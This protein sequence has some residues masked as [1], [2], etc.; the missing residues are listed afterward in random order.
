MKYEMELDPEDVS[1]L[2]VAVVAMKSLPGVDCGRADRVWAALATSTP[3][4]GVVRGGSAMK[5]V[6]VR[7]SLAAA[8]MLRDTLA[9]VGRVGDA[10]AT[11]AFRALDDGIDAAHG[12][13]LTVETAD[14][15]WP[16][17]RVFVRDAPAE[18]LGPVRFVA[19]DVLY[20]CG[21]AY[22]AAERFTFPGHRD[23]GLDGGAPPARND[24]PPIES[25]MEPV[26][27]AQVVI[28][29]GRLVGFQRALG[30]RVDDDAVRGL[31]SA[32]REWLEIVDRGVK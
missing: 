20:H 15:R 25:D 11:E 16:T 1:W 32:Y 24:D 19:G 6:T 22:V 5:S 3:I 14:G 31:V 4:A 12:A 7:L 18:S 17:W 29:Y 28:A 30:D 23:P 27:A 2:G 26:P 21:Q 8:V 10:A 9:Q 13:T